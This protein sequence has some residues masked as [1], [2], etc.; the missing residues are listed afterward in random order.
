MFGFGQPKCPQCGMK[1]D[2]KAEDQTYEWN[3]KRFCSEGCKR[4]FRVKTNTGGGVAA[5]CH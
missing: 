4:S 1:L 2:P 3:G 5:S